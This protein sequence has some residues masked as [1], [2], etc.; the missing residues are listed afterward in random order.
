[1][2]NAFN[3]ATPAQQKLYL[4]DGEGTQVVLLARDQEHLLRLH[5]TASGHDYPTSIVIEGGKVMAIGIG[6]VHRELV[7]PITA[8]L[9]RM[10]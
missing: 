4:A 10:K 9:P 1:M 2:V 6:P 5:A 7:R 8:E 3:K